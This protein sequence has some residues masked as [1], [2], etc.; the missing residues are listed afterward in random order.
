MSNMINFAIDLG[1]S[2]SLIAKFDRGQVEV[3]KN[4]SGFKETLASVVGFRNDRTLIGDQARAYV[5]RDSKSVV[6]RFKRKMGTSESF[7][8]KSLNASKTPV[9][10]SAY[11]LKELK[12]FVQ[13]GEKIDSAVIT[14][15]ASFDSLQSNAT[16]EAGIA[17]GFKNVVL[18]QEPI[19][20]SLA[21]ANKEKNIDLKNSQWLVYDLGGA[22]FDAALVRIVEGEL[23]VVD[24]EGDNYLGGTDFDALLVEKVVVPEINRRGTFED[25]LGQ[26]KSQSGR[27][28]PLWHT[29]LGKAE[30]AK[31]ELSAKTATEIDL[32]TIKVEDDDGKEIDSIITITRSD[33]ES[34]I[35]DYVE[36]TIDMVKKIL[37]RNSLQPS[38]LKFILMVGGSSYIPYV[39]KRVQEVLGLDVNTSIDPT[40]AIVVGAAYFAG[41][42]EKTFQSESKSKATNTRLKVRTSY[43]KTSQDLEE[44]FGAKVEGDIAGLQY[45]VVSDDGAFDSGLKKLGARI[46]EDLPLREGAYNVFYLKIFDSQGSAVQLDVDV[47]QIAQGRYSVA[48]QMLPEDISLVVDDVSANDTR[49]IPVFMK[50]TVLPAQT[51]KTQEVG[52]TIV[53]GSTDEIRIIVVEGP[54]NRHSSTNKPLG[55]LVI[56]GKQV[57]RDLI[58]G[59]EVDFKFSMSES[60]DLTVAAYL[61]GTDQEFSQVFNPQIR[62]VS[63]AVLATETLTLETK[64]QK[65]IEEAEG[66][67]QRDVAGGLEKVLSGVQDLMGEVAGLA[68][69]DV[70][71]KK[72][73]LEDKKRAL[74]REMYELTS[75]KRIEQARK[76]YQDAKSETARLVHESGNDR[77]RNQLKDIVSREPTFSNSS[78]PDKIQAEADSL[79]SIQWGIL[80]RTPDFLKGWFQNLSNKRPTMNDQI[81]ATQLVDSG[82]RAIAREDWDELRQ[83]VGRLWDLIPAE[84]QNKA[85]I[86][87]FTGLV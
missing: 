20:A 38:D 75:G 53:K 73:Q 84:S 39:R 12:G 44:V 78:N 14:I 85:D 86:R 70:T 80:F 67:G 41:T 23:T 82:K 56:S 5:Q 46:L 4:P 1:T 76:D 31:V 50:N 60:R 24:H 21:Y 63:T 68:A 43:N 83:I 81:Q 45:R 17:A 7:Q 19:A 48:G 8:I 29:L 49:L 33:F 51:P 6:S 79:R 59:T 52:R 37:T 26:M 87:M 27:Y 55:M 28:N 32:A 61:N 54:S 13:T 42:K 65:E 16:K 2:N 36:T 72:Y 58:K 66:S 11:V 40:N 30:E 57:S 10:L 71:D 64:L 74:A 22:T 18:L 77:E 3:F 15:P 9:E 34:V 35:K 25:L 69:D 47:I 62:T